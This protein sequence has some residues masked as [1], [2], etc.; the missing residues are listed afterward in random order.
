MEHLGPILVAPD[1]VFFY[2]QCTVVIRFLVIHKRC[3]ALMYAHPFLQVERT[4]L[5]IGTHLRGGA[6]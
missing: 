5:Q 4:Q 6:Q 2:M 3:F 1:G